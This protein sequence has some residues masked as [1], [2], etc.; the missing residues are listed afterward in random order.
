VSAGLCPSE[1]WDSDKLDVRLET[2]HVDEEIDACLSKCLHASRMVREGINMVDPDGIRSKLL[3]QSSIKLALVCVDQ[4][5]VGNELISNA[6]KG[7][8]VSGDAVI[9]MLGR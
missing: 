7:M 2:V 5:I 9:K 4:G 6:W 8:K 1:Y 3:H